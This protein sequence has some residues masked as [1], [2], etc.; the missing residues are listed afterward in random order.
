[1]KKFFALTLALAMGLTM[2]SFMGCDSLKKTLNQ[3]NDTTDVQSAPT[4]D[5]ADIPFK[6]KKANFETEAI[7]PAPGEKVSDAP[8]QKQMDT[9]IQ[10]QTDTPVQKQ[11]DVPVQKQE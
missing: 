4:Q 11:A 1:M 2:I 3:S 9:P 5:Q 10:K 7:P 6:G 8:I